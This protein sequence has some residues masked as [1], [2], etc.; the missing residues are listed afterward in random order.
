MFTLQLPF[1]FQFNCL[2]FKTSECS[3]I[4]RDWAKSFAVVKNYFG[5][6]DPFSRYLYKVF[7]FL[8]FNKNKLISRKPLMNEIFVIKMFI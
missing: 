6:F 8:M 5:D 1:Q 7:N 4:F 2:L 3:R